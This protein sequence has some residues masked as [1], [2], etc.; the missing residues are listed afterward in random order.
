MTGVDIDH[1]VRD[2]CWVGFLGIVGFGLCCGVLRT[3]AIV[4]YMTCWCNCLESMY[5]VMLWSCGLETCDVTHARLVP[6]DMILLHLLA[7]IYFKCISS[8]LQI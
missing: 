1:E 2:E 5:Y 6:C 4:G 7:F 3:C 8:I